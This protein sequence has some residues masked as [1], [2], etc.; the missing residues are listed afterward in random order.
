MNDREKWQLVIALELKTMVKKAVWRQVKT[1]KLPESRKPID[2]KW[3]F[4]KKKI[5]VYHAKLVALC[6]NQIPGVDFFDNFAPDVNDTTFRCLL[7]LAI[8]KKWDMEVIDIET[9]F[10]Y[11]DLDVEIYMKIPSGMKEVFGVDSNNICL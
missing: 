7:V 4:K 1:S 6:Y 2:S 10:L 11:G 8:T 9:A 3:V 5:S